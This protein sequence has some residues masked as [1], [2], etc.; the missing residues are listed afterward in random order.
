MIASDIDIDAVFG[1]IDLL[2]R[3]GRQ[4]DML[5]W[6]PVPRGDD[7]ITDVSVGVIG[8]EVDERVTHGLLR[9]IREGW[10]D[11]ISVFLKATGRRLCA[12]KE[13]GWPHSSA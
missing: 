9:N 2:H 11:F 13:N 6:P 8:E 3:K 7:E 10:P 4:F 12:H 1:P 5:A